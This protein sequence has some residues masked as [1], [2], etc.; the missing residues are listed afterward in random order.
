MAFVAL[1]TSSPFWYV[2]MNGSQRGG[3]SFFELV[4]AELVLVVAAGGR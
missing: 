4:D 2:G 3:V 1:P